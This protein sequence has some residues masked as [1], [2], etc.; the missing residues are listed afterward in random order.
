MTELVR[1]YVASKEIKPAFGKELSYRLQIINRLLDENKP[2]DAVTYMQDFLAH[3]HD[4]AVQ[5]QGLISASAVSVLDSY[6]QVLIHAWS[7]GWGLSNLVLG[8]SYT[9]SKPAAN[10]YS[11]SGNELTNGQFGIDGMAKGAVV[12]PTTP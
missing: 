8:Q 3:I 9:I 7:D 12:S 6:A 10:N 2:K 4:P 11:D 5:A 1:R